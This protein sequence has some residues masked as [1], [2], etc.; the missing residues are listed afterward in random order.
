MR[1]LAV[2]VDH[3]SAPPP[4]ARPWPSR[5]PGAPRGWKPL[6]QTF[7]GNEFVILSTCNRVEIYAR[8][9]PPDRALRPTSLSDFLVEF[10]GVRS[11]GLLR[12]PGGLSRRR[13][14]RPPLPRRLQPGKPGA[15]RGADPG[16]G[17]RGLPRRGRAQDGRPDLPHGLSDGPQ[18]GQEGP[19]ADGH[20]P[21]QALGRQRGGRPGQGGFR[22]LRRQDRAGDRRRQDGRP[23][24]PAPARP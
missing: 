13:R 14:R 15:G 1:L 8:R 18:G 5:A 17:P 2:G 6:P 12:P 19:R 20:G 11:G 24:P 3:R 22:H 4:S 7:P 9:Q 21:G 23:D 16:P 10:H